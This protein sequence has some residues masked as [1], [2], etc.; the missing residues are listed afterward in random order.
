MDSLL[1][2]L[3][4]AVAILLAASWLALY[5]RLRSERR[6]CRLAEGRASA[7]LDAAVDGVVTI[8]ENGLIEAFNSGAERVFGYA[9]AE[10]L[11]RNVKVLMPEPYRSDHDGYLAAYKATG[12]ARIIGIG[13]EVMGLRKDGSTFPMDLA[14]GESRVA[15]KRVFA[16]ICRDI[17][18]RKEAEQRL[19]DS[20][21]RFR[22]I[23]DNVRDYAISWLDLHGRIVSWNEGAGRLYGWNA[24]HVVGKSA[25]ILYP[26]ED[27][28]EAAKALQ[29]VRDNGR[30]EGEGWRIRKDGSRFWAHAVVTPL[31]DDD[32]R[33][34]GYVRV[35]QDI[36]ERR[37]AELAQ[38]AAREDA[39]RANRAKS[40]FLAAASHDL[41]QPVQALVF[42]TSALEGQVGERAKPLL[43]E[44]QGSLEAMNE[45]LDA[46]LDVSRLDAGVVTPEDSNV[47]LSPLLERLVAELAP[48]AA[49]KN[50]R[51][52]V[53]PTSAIVRTDGQLFARIIRNLLS[54]AVK[55]TPS[56]RILVG[57]RRQGRR[58]RVE[59]WD[60]GIG[61]AAEHLDDIFQEFYQIENA[62][63]DRSQG[64]GLG[65]A[66]VQR[67]ARLLNCHVGVRSQPGKGS[68][69][70]VDAPV[71]GFNHSRKV[72]YLD[73]ATA[74]G[75]RQGKPVVLVVDDEAAVLKG[76]SL[77][78][79]EWGY[80]VL[81]AA[82]EEEALEILS[83]QNREPDIIV[84]D[85]RL[86]AGATG[87]DVI[88]H[89]RTAFDRPIP[90]MIITGDTAP[91][92]IR[93]VQSHGLN[94]LH[95]PVHPAAL[96]AFISDAV[97]RSAK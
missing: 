31:W 91:E 19:R 30:Y 45:L 70:S 64:L 76:L 84:A 15:G 89:I 65:L 63:R 21:E 25:E 55:Y 6:A 28:D 66:I 52:K 90:S 50:L 34:R 39:E 9:A 59:V 86:R 46:L 85:Y 38:R 49:E 22:L 8:D 4:I 96:K 74:D 92:R 77:V 1:S 33:L 75:H 18:A 29:A 62:S 72:S 88:R 71:V 32:G 5:L 95:K 81:A 7:I 20:E 97:G 43:A 51:V 2:F 54:N 58:I 53:L 47:G 73:K 79:E 56:G 83:R 36:T 14:V 60:T 93:E 61:M 42:F 57:C 17:T 12:R 13:R 44:L 48:Q 27:R 41:R 69:F 80:E 11:G 67:L 78:I 35:S 26:A 37:Q 94:I 40:R 23:I 16:G 24:D 10:V 87:A 68:V 3:A 82:G